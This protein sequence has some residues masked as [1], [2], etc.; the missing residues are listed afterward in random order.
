MKKIKIIKYTIIILILFLGLLLYIKPNKEKILKSQKSNVSESILSL[1]EKV[2]D[3]SCFLNDKDETISFFS[4]AFGISKENI[5]NDLSIIN[6]DEDFNELNIGKLKDDEGNYIEY[7]SF[8]MGLIEYLFKYSKENPE[9]VDNTYNPYNG[10]SEYVENLIKYFTS[11][12]TNVDYI[13]AISIGAA[14][15]GYYKVGYMLNCNNIYGG[16]SGGKLI[17]YKNIEYGV[18][19]FIRFLNNSYYSKGVTELASIG[20]SYCPTYDEQGNKIASPHWINL[21]NNAKNHYASTTND[22]LISDILNVES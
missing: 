14:E 22:I 13:T 11:I 16:M 6:A 21:V 3:I 18:L 4:D 19:S 9:N 15:S 7:S 8:E 12:Y 5:I 20:R 2:C 10:S 17:I 1:N